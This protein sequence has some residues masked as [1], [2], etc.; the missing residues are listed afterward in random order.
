MKDRPSRLSR[1]SLSCQAEPTTSSR[2]VHA[3]TPFSRGVRRTGLGLEQPG[4]AG[5]YF[6]KDRPGRLQAG[7]LA[8]GSSS[9]RTFPP[10]L[11]VKAVAIRGVRHRSQ[12]RVRGRLA[13]PSLFRSK[14]ERTCNAGNS[15]AT[16]GRCQEKTFTAKTQK[17]FVVRSSWFVAGK[18]AMASGE[19]RPPACHFA[20]RPDG[21]V[22]PVLVTLAPLRRRSKA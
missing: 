5:P 1:K 17:K 6:A 10:R 2:A 7:L 20:L 8:S 9:R 15:S 14:Q 21:G 11:R 22:C 16:P 13:R 4:P 19:A 12:R 3:K 18:K